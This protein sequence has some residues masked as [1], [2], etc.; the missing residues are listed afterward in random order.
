MFAIPWITCLVAG[1]LLGTVSASLFYRRWLRAEQT[2][3]EAGSQIVDTAHG[4]VEYAS[5]GDGPVILISHGGGGGYDNGLLHL[6]ALAPVGFRVIAVSR[7]GYLRTPAQVGRT[8]EAMADTYA[9][10]LDALNISRA[11]IVG[12]SAGGPSAIQFA[13]RYPERCW[14]LGLISAIT[15][16]FLNGGRKQFFKRL[17]LADVALWLMSMFPPLR[18]RYTRFVLA[19]VVP[20]PADRAVLL[21]DPDKLARL[22]RVEHV[23]GTNHLRRLGIAIDQ[24]QWPLIPVY[25]VEQI[26]APTL[27]IHG[28]ADQTVP[29]VHAE[30][31]AQTAP[32]AELV[33]LSGAGHALLLTH[34]QALH[35]LIEFLKAQAPAFP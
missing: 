20:D 24:A 19:Q 5:V 23:G 2:R 35:R 28:A 6:R 32:H 8:P 22:A 14:A 29:L 17:G 1:L 33:T 18:Q 9:A 10:L 27:L 13:L 25:P 16:Q 31:V 11:A 12:L 15:R 34:P 30:F 3:V 21:A 7:A 26:T 4:P